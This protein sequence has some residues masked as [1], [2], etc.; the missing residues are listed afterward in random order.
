[1]RLAP[2]SPERGLWRNSMGGE[3]K[4]LGRVGS[5]T[6]IKVYDLNTLA[7]DIAYAESY[8]DL[9]KTTD[10]FIVTAAALQDCGYELIEPAQDDD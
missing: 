1:M 7:G 9:F 2:A 8:D 3:L 6:G 5:M 4:V 10:R